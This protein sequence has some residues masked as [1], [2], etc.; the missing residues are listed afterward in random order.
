MSSYNDCISFKTSTNFCKW[1]ILSLWKQD[2]IVPRV[3]N[4]NVKGAL[5]V[6][7]HEIW[8]F[9][10]IS[11][12]FFF[13]PETSMNSNTVRS[14]FTFGWYKLFI[15]QN[16]IMRDRCLSQLK[17][18]DPICSLK[19]W[20]WIKLMVWRSKYHI[21]TRSISLKIKNRKLTLGWLIMNK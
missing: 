10:S 9:V 3:K 5:M 21:G 6:D 7:E 1:G 18:V 2:F 13:S 20:D 12:S 16:I 17:V 8:L 19:M 14:Q 4:N 11:I 15:E